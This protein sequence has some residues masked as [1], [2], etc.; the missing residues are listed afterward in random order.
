MD[1]E[2]ILTPEQQVGYIGRPDVPNSGAEPVLAGSGHEILP[3]KLYLGP[4]SCAD[5]NAGESLRE[6]N[7]T[8]I[9]NCTEDC[10][11]HH[12][13]SIEYC[14]VS[15]RDEDF[16]DIG[17]YLESATK[18]IHHHVDV[19]QGAVVVHCRQGISRSASV[20]IAYLMRYHG[21]SLEEAYVL[22][23]TRRPLVNP[24]PGFWKQLQEFEKRSTQEAN[25][26]RFETFDEAWA[27]QSCATFTS[28]SSAECT[29]EK[30]RI[31][32]D[33]D[34]AMVESILTCALD[35]VFGHGVKQSDVGWLVALSEALPNGST[36]SALRLLDRSSSF[37]ENWN[38]DVSDGDLAHLVDPLRASLAEH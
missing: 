26:S 25:A 3:G 38:C 1:S 7:I 23:K 8:G 19:Q 37:M 17:I 31:R 12:E 20:V 4:K 22:A 9:V 5:E 29:F 27:K 35:H 33:V 11:C 13:P 10:Q 16:A 32:G 6:A 24:N 34:T 30:L 36:D 2:D 14:R 18:F 21:M 28:T 15:V